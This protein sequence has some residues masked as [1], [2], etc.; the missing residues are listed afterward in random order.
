VS[1]CED[2][3]E[4]FKTIKSPNPPASAENAI[5]DPSGDQVGL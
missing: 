4:S 2:P 3:S 5:D 1:G